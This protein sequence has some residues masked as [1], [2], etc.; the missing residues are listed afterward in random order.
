LRPPGLHA[1]R[2]PNFLNSKLFLTIPPRKDFPIPCFVFWLLD[3][4][5]EEPLKTSPSESDYCVVFYLQ[6]IHLSSYDIVILIGKVKN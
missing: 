2:H 5:I 6:S 4:R 3:K 1:R